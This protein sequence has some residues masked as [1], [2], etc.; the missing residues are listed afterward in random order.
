[1]SPAV[2]DAMQ[3]MHDVMDESFSA[4]LVDIKSP[5]EEGLVIAMLNT[6]CAQLRYEMSV[7]VKAKK[8]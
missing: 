6:V 2:E 4:I 1:M 8:T 7:Y 3:Q 5:E